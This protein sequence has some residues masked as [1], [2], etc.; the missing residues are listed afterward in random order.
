VQEIDSAFWGAVAQITPVLALALVLDIRR[1][2][3]RATSKSRGVDLPDMRRRLALARSVFGVGAFVCAAGLAAAFLTALLVL[4][5]GDPPSGRGRALTITFL[6]YALSF[7][8]ILPTGEVLARFGI[9]TMFSEW[10]IRRRRD[11]VVD[12]LERAS[13]NDALDARGQLSDLYV[14]AYR[15]FRLRKDRTPQ[16]TARAERDL[17][18]V[19]A[20][21][22]AARS[23]LDK[24]RAKERKYFRRRR[25]PK[26]YDE[27]SDKVRRFIRDGVT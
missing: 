26:F 15:T 23:L 9:W 4:G 13:L 6:V 18:R 14:Q 2:M 16:G 24:T 8:V 12:R 5:G 19:L 21:L 22:D 27:L 10:E 3:Q 17:E 7:I 20:E 25:S 1:L 11:E